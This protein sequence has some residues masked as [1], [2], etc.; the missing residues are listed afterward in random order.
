MSISLPSRYE[1][2][3]EAYRGRL[4]PD[5]KLL[6][7][8]NVAQKAM[9][10]S[11]GIR[12]LPVYGES[13]SGKTCAAREISTHLPGVKT[14]LLSRDQ[15]ESK[16]SL[17]SAIQYQHTRNPGLIL[18]AI[19][20]QYEETVIGKERIPTQFVEYISLFDRGELSKIPTIFLW[21]TTSKDFQKQLADA[22]SRN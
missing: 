2:L 22:T 6:N 3:D 4:V 11:G 7:I 19:I 5:G 9:K 16:E 8:V 12:F 20:D 17:L 10:I 14:F 13:G 1:D 15:I 18:I 21:L